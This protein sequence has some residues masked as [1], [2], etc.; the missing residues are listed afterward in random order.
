MCGQR[1]RASKVAAL[2]AVAAL[3]V[4]GALAQDE[5]EPRPGESTEQ[6][7]PHFSGMDEAVNVQLAERAGAPVRKPYLDVESLGDLWNFILLAAGGICGFVVGRFWD[8]IWGRP[9]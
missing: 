8:Q 2:A 3:S 4:G 6:P 5:P 9:K 7:E 1:I